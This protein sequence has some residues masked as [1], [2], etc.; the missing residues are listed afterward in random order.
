MGCRIQS[1]R[2]RVGRQQSQRDLDALQRRRRRSIAGGHHPPAS[3]TDKGTPTGITYN[4]TNDFTVVTNAPPSDATA[5]PARFIFASED[6]AITAWAPGITTALVKATA[7]ANYKGIA[8]AANGTANQLYAADFVGRKID[9]YTKCLRAHDG[10]GRLP[11]PEAAGR[12][13]SLQHHEHPG[14]P[15]RGVRQGRSPQ[16]KSRQAPDSAS[17]TCSTRTASC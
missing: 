2:V 15:V 8:I 14:Q 1:Q 17:S 3:G 10:A 11:R 13:Q 9:V 7:D 16:T 5:T 12:L 4:G 6:G